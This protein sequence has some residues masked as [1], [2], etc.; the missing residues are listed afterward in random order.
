MEKKNK[1]EQLRLWI[2]KCACTAK[3][4]KQRHYDEVIS[5][6]EKKNFYSMTFAQ[7]K[8]LVWLIDHYFDHHTRDRTFKFFTY[9]VDKHVRKYIKS[10]ADVVEAYDHNFWGGEGVGLYLPLPNNKTIRYVLDT[11]ETMSESKGH[12]YVKFLSGLPNREALKYTLNF[13]EMIDN[14]KLLIFLSDKILAM[15]EWAKKTGNEDRLNK[16]VLH[17]FLRCFT[18]DQFFKFFTSDR[19]AK[20]CF[21]EDM[22]IGKLA[23]KLATLFVAGCNNTFGGWRKLAHLNIASSNQRLDALQN[24]SALARHEAEF[25]ILAKDAS[26][27]SQI[28]LHALEALRMI[29]LGGMTPI[30]KVV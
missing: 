16:S 3:G 22:G 23:Q 9:L 7:L 27:E 28:Q 6:T 30:M 21:R 19:L 14:Q 17:A 24:M 4:M 12:V 10:S 18:F 2:I 11:F 15:I 26:N 13:I 1:F 29:R 25:E 20:G 5:L 8:S